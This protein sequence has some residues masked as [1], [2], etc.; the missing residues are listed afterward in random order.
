MKRILLVV[1]LVFVA[2]SSLTLV[3]MNYHFVTGSKVS[4]VR[5]LPKLSWPL[6]ETLIN[7][8]AVMNMPMIAVRAQYPLYMAQLANSARDAKREP[9]LSAERVGSLK[10]GM[11]TYQAYDLLGKPQKRV[12][13]GQTDLLIY[14]APLA[15]NSVTIEVSND[16][17]ILKVER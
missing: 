15:G 2:I 11:K 16:G 7:E 17:Y 10:P 5:I 6:S 14:E 13:A 9:D 12:T 1:A 3:A 4:G 8:D